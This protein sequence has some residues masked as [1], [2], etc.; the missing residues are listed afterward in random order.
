MKFFDRHGKMSPNR[1]RA[2]GAIKSPARQLPQFPEFPIGD[3]AF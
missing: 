2:S 1:L 3:I